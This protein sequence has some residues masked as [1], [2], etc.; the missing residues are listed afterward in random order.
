[1]VIFRLSWAASFLFTMLIPTQRERKCKGVSGSEEDCEERRRAR[2]VLILSK[3]RWRP[4]A[5]APGVERV[6]VFT[7]WPTLRAAFGVSP[8]TTTHPFVPWTSH[9]SHC[10]P[11]SR[12]RWKPWLRRGRAGGLCREECLAQPRVAPFK[13]L[14]PSLS[15]HPRCWCGLS[16]PYLNLQGSTRQRWRLIEGNRAT[17]KEPENLRSSASVTVY[18]AQHELLKSP[19]MHDWINTDRIWRCYA[20]TFDGWCHCV[21]RL[22]LVQSASACV[23]QIKSFLRCLWP[24]PLLINETFAC[25]HSHSNLLP[26]IKILSPDYSVLH[27]RLRFIKVSVC[28]REIISA[29]GNWLHIVDSIYWGGE[30]KPVWITGKRRI[31]FCI[32]SWLHL[33]SVA[34]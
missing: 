34:L 22:S 9:S 13:A 1:M 4:R 5:P 26:V 11:L 2:A 7:I 8:H 21:N 23:A 30:L 27:T 12:F 32:L 31:K 15:D 16:E 3:T 17:C 29:R 14:T 33:I 20:R 25:A 19:L 24:L 28:L 18:R 6:D 10:V